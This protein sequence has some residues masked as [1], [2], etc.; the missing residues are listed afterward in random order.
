MTFYTTSDSKSN[1]PI[2]K[3]V[4]QTATG[5][6]NLSSANPNGNN[7]RKILSNGTL[8]ILRDGETYNA[9]GIKQP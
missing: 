9:Q 2:Y 1:T 4:R 5:I 8:L 3:Y 7:C 6:E